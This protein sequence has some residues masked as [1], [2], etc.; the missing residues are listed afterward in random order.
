MTY[1][2]AAFFSMAQSDYAGALIAFTALTELSP[3]FAEGWK[4]QGD[5]VLPDG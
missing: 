3:E 1:S 2:I 4:P 5:L